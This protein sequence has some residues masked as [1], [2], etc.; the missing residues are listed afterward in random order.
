M[1]RTHRLKIL[2]CSSANGS[3]GY[4]RPVQK[5]THKSADRRVKDDEKLTIEPEE[6]AADT[7]KTEMQKRRRRREVYGTE[8]SRRMECVKTTESQSRFAGIAETIGV[9]LECNHVYSYNGGAVM[10]MKG[11][12]CVAIA[13][14]RH[15]G[16]QAQMVT[17][18][19]QKIFPLGD[20]LLG[21]AGLATVVQ[22]VAQSLK[23]RLNL[24][25]LKEGRQIKPYT[26]MSM[27]ANLLYGKW[28]SPYNTEPI[29]A[30]LDLKT[31]KS[32][33]CSLDLIG[34]PMVIDDFVVRG[35]CSEQMYGMCE[36]LWE[37]NMDPEYLFETISQ[38][39][40]NAVDQYAM[41]G[42]GVIIHIIEKDKISTRTLKARMD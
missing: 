37:P 22:T 7:S 6:M 8:D 9:L 1:L 36:S 35:T 26:L 27:V 29:I 16:I 17:T 42:M 23:F 33:I 21:L 13:V 41:S 3:D 30:D 31:F 39:M 34:C 2:H 32:F 38:A 15:F 40:L 10:A 20:R 25:E 12:N 24:Y 4:S 11:K 5:W 14:D 18:D 28:F 19:F